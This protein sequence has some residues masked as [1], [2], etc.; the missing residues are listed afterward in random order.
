MILPVAFGYRA[1]QAKGRIRYTVMRVRGT[2]LRHLVEQQSVTLYAARNHC[3]Q[4]TGP[5]SERANRHSYGPAAACNASRL[6]GSIGLKVQRTRGGR[7]RLAR[8]AGAHGNSTPQR[9]YFVRV[10]TRRWLVEVHQPI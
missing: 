5:L 3:L 6:C 9:G 8:R 1:T 10:R 2:R 7:W 4:G